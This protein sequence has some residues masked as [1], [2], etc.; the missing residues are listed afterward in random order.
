MG[1]REGGRKVGAVWKQV[2]WSHGD[3]EEPGGGGRSLENTFSGDPDVHLKT[4]CHWAQLIRERPLR[5]SA[6][7]A[8]ASNPH[9]TPANG[10]SY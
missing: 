1:G 2:D 3:T 5:G 6:P 8:R 4:I 9:S 7:E 10:W